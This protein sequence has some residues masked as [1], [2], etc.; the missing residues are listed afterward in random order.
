MSSAIWALA[1]SFSACLLSSVAHLSLDRPCA[2]GVPAR[3]NPGFPVDRRD[4]PAD[5]REL[6]I[7]EPPVLLRESPLTRLKLALKVAELGARW[8]REFVAKQRAHL[9]DADV[10]VGKLC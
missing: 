2:P 4:I 1:S 3:C 10:D 8:L 6:L 9:S 7:L 5:P